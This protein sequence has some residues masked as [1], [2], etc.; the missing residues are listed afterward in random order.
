MY[1]GKRTKKQANIKADL[2]N[3]NNGNCSRTEMDHPRK[4]FETEFTSKA[5]ADQNSMNLE[6][7]QMR[8]KRDQRTETTNESKC[9][10][11]IKKKERCGIYKSIMI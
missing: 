11:V 4:S 8:S 2:S 1:C 6:K 10:S 9:R 3:N 7:K 5:K